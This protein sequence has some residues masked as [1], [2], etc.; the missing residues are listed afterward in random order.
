MGLAVSLISGVNY[1]IDSYQSQALEESYNNVFDLGFVKEG[2]KSF[3]SDF[4]TEQNKITLLEMLENN[5][6]E[7]QGLYPSIYIYNGYSISAYTESNNSWDQSFYI[8]TPDF[9]NSQNFQHY[10]YLLSG[11]Y[12]KADNEVLILDDLA[13]YLNLTAGSNW[14]IHP[15]YDMDKAKK[16][17]PFEK[18]LLQDEIQQ[19]LRD[20]PYQ[21]NYPKISEITKCPYCDSLHINFGLDKRK[22]QFQLHNGYIITRA[23]LYCEDCHKFDFKTVKLENLDELKED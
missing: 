8:F 19:H 7:I 18:P 11:Q 6:F 1:Y 10:F 9:Y 15:E 23:V 5:D 20:K 14:S 12:P 4:L 13:K 17:L 21:K 2:D 3:S 16:G 22:G